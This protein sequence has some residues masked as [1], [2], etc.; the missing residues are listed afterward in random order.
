MFRLKIIVTIPKKAF[1]QLNKF[2]SILAFKNEKFVL[3]SKVYHVIQDFPFNRENVGLIYKVRKLYILAIKCIC[4]GRNRLNRGHREL[5]DGR[6]RRADSEQ[7]PLVSNI[8][9]VAIVKFP[10]FHTNCKF[11]GFFVSTISY[12]PTDLSLLKE[13]Y[14]KVDY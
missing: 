11:Y 2:W 7:R 3:V 10:Q 5:L 8:T 12:K 1:G 6:L 9:T 14:K 13:F 4:L